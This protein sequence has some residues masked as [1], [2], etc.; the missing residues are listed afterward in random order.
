MQFGS[1]SAKPPI[2]VAFDSDIGNRIDSVLALAL[3][4]GFDT[5]NE[6]RTVLVTTSKPNLKSAAFCDAVTKFYAA[7]GFTRTL[8]VGMPER[9]PGAEDTP[10]LKVADSYPNGI[11]K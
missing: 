8:P 1:S 6:C 3:L 7:G 10:I 2:G 4:Y 9:G 11:K 5:K